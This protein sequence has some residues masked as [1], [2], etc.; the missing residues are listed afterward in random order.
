M[1]PSPVVVSLAAL[2]VAGPAVLAESQL[3]TCHGAWVAN[4]INATGITDTDPDD[5]T[6][7]IVR[8]TGSDVWGTADSLHYASRRISGTQ[9]ITA[10]VKSLAN[11]AYHGKAGLMIRESL[12][13][14]SRHVTIN[15]TPRGWIEV[16]ARRAADGPTSYVTGTQS[17]FP[18]VPVWLKLLRHLD[19]TSVYV[20]YD[21]QTWTHA[22]SIDLALSQRAYVGLV[23]T[24]GNGAV[25]TA[26]FDNIE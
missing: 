12:D 13:A 14:G 23:V 8:S 20:S 19:R 7:L 16:L 22:A 15:L 18:H 2:L 21:N 10:R 25:A 9:Q 6:S 11:A 5:R 24:S 3:C 17:R 26:T 1:S 4:S